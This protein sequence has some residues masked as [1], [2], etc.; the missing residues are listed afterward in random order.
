MHCEAEARPSQLKK[1]ASKPLRAEADASRTTSLIYIGY[2]SGSFCFFTN[3][4]IGEISQTVMYVCEV[5]R[6]YNN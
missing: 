3:A 1:T 4:V 5:N 6:K 2:D